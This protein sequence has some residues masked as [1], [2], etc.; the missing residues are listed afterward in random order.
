MK[1]CQCSYRICLSNLISHIQFPIN[2][3]ELVTV[4]W[5]GKVGRNYEY[6]LSFIK[7]QKWLGVIKKYELWKNISKYN[8]V[9]HVI[10]EKIRIIDAIPEITAPKEENKI[11]IEN[12]VRSLILYGST[13]RSQQN[14]EWINK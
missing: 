11:Q 14:N 5:Q 12:V 3:K 1:S 4:K 8:G 13:F 6:F 7:E 10:I 9:Q 2:K